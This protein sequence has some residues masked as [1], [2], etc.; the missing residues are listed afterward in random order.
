MLGISFNWFSTNV[1]LKFAQDCV[2]Y[3]DIRECWERRWSLDKHYTQLQVLT[4]WEGSG[5]GCHFR[6]T[7]N[8]GFKKLVVNL[9]EE[10][11]LVKQERR[12]NRNRRA[13]IKSLFERGLEIVDELPGYDE[14]DVVGLTGEIVMGDFIV[15]LTLEPIFPKWRYTGTSKS[16]GIDLVARERS[17]EDW[18]LI[19][20]EAKHLHNEIRS[21]GAKLCHNL[22]R[23]RFKIGIDEFELDKTKLNLANLLM[24][25]GDFI[26]LG[27]ATGSD[28]SLTN[29]YRNL[30]SAGLKNDRYRVN[31]VALV[32]AK[33]CNRL[34]FGQS[35]SNISYPLQI[36]ES[37]SLTLTLIEST[38][39]EEVTDEVCSNFVGAI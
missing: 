3:S 2:I 9:I 18:D 13:V 32:D 8:D 27:E 29:E 33:Y 37:H 31:V 38:Y 36:G 10:A 39:L 23:N 21:A 11:R 12:R 24:K 15:N 14:T 5:S 25:L 28:V 20:Y 17:G 4:L 7:I 34:T 30:I 19:L 22:V 35:V 16:S 1:L 6:M 26:R